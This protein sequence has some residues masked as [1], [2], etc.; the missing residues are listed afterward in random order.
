M[1]D[2]QAVTGVTGEGL[3]QIESYARDTAKAFGIDAA[4]AVESYKLILGQLYPG[5]AKESRRTQG[6]GRARCDAL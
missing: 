3:K 5:A 6:D 1:T 4:G 2:L